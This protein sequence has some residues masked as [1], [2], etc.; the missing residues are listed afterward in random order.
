[1]RTDVLAPHDSGLDPFLQRFQLNRLLYALGDQRSP[2]EIVP[3]PDNPRE[4]GIAY[5]ERA[6]CLLARIWGEAW[7]GRQLH[8]FEIVREATPILRLF[9]RN[10]RE[11][12]DWTSWYVA[13]GARAQFYVLLVD[14]SAQHGAQATE[15]MRSAFEQKWDNPETV[16]FWPT[17][18][19]RQ[20]ILAFGRHGSPRNWV[21]EKLRDL[22]GEMLDGRDASGRVEECEQQAK[23]WLALGDKES[24]RHQIDQM[25]R[26]SFA[27][28]YRKDYQLNTWIE[29]LGDINKIEGDKAAERIAWFARA[30]TSLEETTEGPAARYAA[31]ELLAVAHRWSPRRAISLFRFFFD[32][33]VIWHE[34]AVRVLLWKALE[35]DN[36]PT[37]AVTLSLANFVLPV[38][39]A[40]DPELVALL[41][42]QTASSRGSQSALETAQHVLGKANI[43][44]LPSTR[45][46]WRRGIAHGLDQLG[47]DLRSAGLG[48]ADLRPDREGEGSAGL[49]RLKDGSFLTL[50]EAKERVSSISDL[51]VLMAEAADGPWF[52]WELVV[53]QLTKNADPAGFQALA[54][55]FQ[56]SHRSAQIL[57]TLSET[58]SAR[59]QVQ[60][61]WCVGE[62]ALGKSKAY[63]WDRRYDG[64]SRIAAFRALVRAE[65]GRGRE[66]TWGTLIQ[67]LR[68]EYWYPQ[69][70]ALNLRDILPLLCEPLPVREIWAEIEQY[71]RCLFESSPLPAGG[72]VDLDLQPARDSASAAIADL[73]VLHIDH[74][75]IAVAQAAQKT[76]AE[77]MLTRE[78]AMEKATREVLGGN[79]SQ[80]QRALMVLDAVSLRKPGV[81]AAFKQ[82]ILS[83]YASPNYGIQRAAQILGERLGVRRPSVALPIIALPAIYKLSLPRESIVGLTAPRDVS[84]TAP[85][86]DSADPT[87]LVGPWYD[88][89]RAVAEE[90]R[91]PAINVCYRAVQ[92]MRDMAP[93]SSWNRQGERRLMN[94]LDQ[95][96][97]RIAFRRPRAELAHRAIFHVV[98]ELVSA[99]ILDPDKLRQLE[100]VLRS[101]DPVMVLAEPTLRPVDI[102]PI[103]GSREPGSRREQWPAQMKLPYEPVK[104]KTAGGFVILAEETRLRRLEWGAPS[105]TRRSVIRAYEAQSLQQDSGNGSLFAR[106]VNRLV[107]EYPTL[108]VDTET[109]AF[110]IRHE[111]Y[112]YESSGQNWLALNPLVARQLEWNWAEDGLFR[113]ADNDGQTMVES[114]WWADGLVGQSP[115]HLED[116]VGEGWLV[117][118][119]EPAW[120]AMESLVPN[121][122]RVVYVKR[123]YDHEG[124]PIVREMRDEEV[125]S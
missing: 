101:Y 3:D 30:I 112:G 42:Q 47:L 64:G 35:A 76:V 8:G 37:Q 36:P 79:E 22:E 87:E 57:A 113:W 21:V 43:Y 10:W 85:L 60:E 90:A 86:P 68:E 91:L 100:E 9:N 18:V 45:S 120:E 84:P 93:E 38:A 13:Q 88:H 67:D 39:T 46:A 5:F 81:V 6:L 54:D 72:P 40:A 108:D 96:G 17:D 69:S 116:E 23:A 123:S 53:G 16:Q 82:D 12:R 124:Q 66:R 105:E 19:R 56:P 34:E 89:M 121:L 118:A 109:Q 117:L 31:N 115:P 50:R 74:P 62:Q 95:V 70:I 49:L 119:S 32:E 73:L 107:A 78:P 55:L 63:G 51:Q 111:A 99:G 15:A 65:P 98:A 75:A 114:V 20:V 2:A 25:M 24:A 41:I 61:G 26:M 83:L 71:V 102:E 122:R 59:S 52:D 58:L 27:V 125:V 11:T 110:V 94:A 1:L 44:A 29:W 104:R 77:L 4:Q 97:L 106:A 92:I 28:G 103:A 80:Q 14:A 48:P 7:R 33:G